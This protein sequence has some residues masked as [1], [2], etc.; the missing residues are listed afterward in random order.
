MK[1]DIIK[2]EIL[3]AFLIWSLGNQNSYYDCE[4]VSFIR[5]LS[6]GTVWGSRGGNVHPQKHFFLADSTVGKTLS[7][8]PLLSN[9]SFT[10]QNLNTVQTHAFLGMC[11]GLRAAV[12]CVSVVIWSAVDLSGL[13]QELHGHGQAIG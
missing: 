3:I 5:C 9:F 1:D 13:S 4:H 2:R 7:Q 8:F 11:P 12:L 6:W 10:L